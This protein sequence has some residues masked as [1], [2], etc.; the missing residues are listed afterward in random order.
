MRNSPARGPAGQTMLGGEAV[1]ECGCDRTF[2]RSKSANGMV[3]RF[4]D[5][6]CQ[7]RAAYQRRK[8]GIIDPVRAEV[9]RNASEAVISGQTDSLKF[10]D[11]PYDRRRE[12]TQ[13]DL[14]RDCACVHYGACSE[15]WE[16]GKL[17]KL[18]QAGAKC[19]KGVCYQPSTVSA[20]MSAM[21]GS[22][23]GGSFKHVGPRRGCE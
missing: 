23:Y 7:R 20:G 8:S 3:R 5:G 1:C 9:A 21:S 6:E 19:S 18:E 2:L 13:D 4:F 11:L 22:G 10:R 12:C 16:F 15:C 17:T 14:G